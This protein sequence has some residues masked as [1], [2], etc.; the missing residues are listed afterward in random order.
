MSSFGL[1]ARK[2]C[3]E[4]C[5]DLKL[6]NCQPRHSEVR[7]GR[8]PAVVSH[9]LLSSGVVLRAQPLLRPPLR[10]RVRQ[11]LLALAVAWRAAATAAAHPS[12]LCAVL[13][14][15]CLLM[16]VAA[17]APA[18][19]PA[20]TAAAA[21]AD[22]QFVWGQVSLLVQHRTRLPPHKRCIN[23]AAPHELCVRAHLPWII[24]GSAG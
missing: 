17:A 11:L 18:A 8:E 24:Q 12:A 13:A 14:L 10:Q 20:P 22:L 3:F 23:A 1:E 19:A 7:P 2:K 5:T 9:M 4:L 6:P 16:R 21:A 15:A